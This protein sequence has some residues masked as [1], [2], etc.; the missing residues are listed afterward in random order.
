MLDHFKGGEG[1]FPDHPHRGQ[2]TVTYMMEGAFLHED[3]AGHKGKLGPGDVQWM[4]AGRGIIHAEMPVKGPG[5]PNPEGMQLWVDL[6]K[7]HKMVD[8]SYQELNHKDIPSAY[9]EGEGGPVIKVISGTS[10]GVESPVRPLGGCWYFDIAFQKEGQSIFQ[11]IPQGWT[12]F[13]YTYAGKLLVNSTDQGSG[14]AHEEFHTLVLSSSGNEN[15]VRLAA[16]TDNTRVFLIAGEPLDQPVVQYGP[17]VV[18]SES[19]VHQAIN[20]YRN[21]RN[22]F[23]K[24]LSWKSEIGGS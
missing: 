2:T 3:S 24:A 11:D 12:A 16:A 17:F 13:M 20:D 18:T 5:V 21:G 1:G 4:V 23:E 15:G 19:E 7:A 6:P 8:P 9:P 10:H 22:G 14:A